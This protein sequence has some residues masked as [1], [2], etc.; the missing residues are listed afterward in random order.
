VFIPIYAAG[1]VVVAWV[2]GLLVHAMVKSESVRLWAA[3]LAA[4]LAMGFAVIDSAYE[5]YDVATREDRF[6]VASVN[7]IPLVKRQVLERS[8][9]GGVAII[10]SGNFDAEPGAD[11]LVH[12]TH[13]TAVLSLDSYAVKAQIPFARD[14]CENCVGMYPALVA[15]G[16]GSFLV[17]TSDGVADSRGRLI[18]ANKAEG[19]SRVVPIDSDRNGLA[20]V[21]YNRYDEASLRNVAGEFLWRIKLPVEDVGLYV[22]AEGQR[23]PFAITR[24]NETT[25]LQVYDFTGK[26]VRTV[27]LPRWASNVQSIAWPSSG[28]LLVG[29]GSRFGILDA[30]GKELLRHTISD[31]SF[32]PYH[33]PDGVAAKLCGGNG[34]FLAVM[35]HGSSGYARSVLLVFDPRG[36]LVWQEEMNKARAMLSVPRAGSDREV[37]L[38]A[39]MDGVV[40]YSLPDVQLREPAASSFCSDR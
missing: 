32:N 13:A 6:P 37:I 2:G 27:A 29:Q 31:T 19:F 9:V 24:S 28:H 26:A 8:E 25:Q 23:L 4:V 21:A 20:F 39:G 34:A 30:E 14:Q 17:A 12:S 22:A 7:T 11:L 35:S 16:M 33:G 3:G 5:S 18:W 38:V 15:D 1:V 10:A 40:E 36:K